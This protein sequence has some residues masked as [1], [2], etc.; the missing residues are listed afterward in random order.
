MCAMLSLGEICMDLPAMAT[1]GKAK[2]DTKA[3]NIEHPYST[4]IRATSS[5]SK[6][7]AMHQLT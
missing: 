2:A 7:G 1:A 6:K 4:D 3:P 5:P